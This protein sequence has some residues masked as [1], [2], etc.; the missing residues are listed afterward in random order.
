MYVWVVV[1][2]K[3]FSCEC[4]TLKNISI[5][6]KP[7]GRNSFVGRAG[8]ARHVKDVGSGTSNIPQYKYLTT[9]IPY[10]P[11]KGSPSLHGLQVLVMKRYPHYYG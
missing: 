1:G 3:S 9:V 11:E 7:G 4:N 6:A 8:L 5:S 2:C 10:Q